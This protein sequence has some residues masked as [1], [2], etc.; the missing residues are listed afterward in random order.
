M[1]LISIPSSLNALLP[2][3]PNTS[4]SHLASNTCITKLNIIDVTG[5][6]VETEHDSAA[7]YPVVLLEFPSNSVSALSTIVGALLEKA[8]LKSVT[9]GIVDLSIKDYKSSTEHMKTHYKEL[10]SDPRISW[11]SGTVFVLP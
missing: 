6:A 10:L 4:L 8:T 3:L 5:G 7:F 2:Y 1:S 9:L 11:E